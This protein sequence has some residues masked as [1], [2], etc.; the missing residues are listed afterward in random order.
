[1]DCGHSGAPG[2]MHSYEKIRDKEDKEETE[3][4][5]NAI[6]IFMQISYKTDLISR[7]SCRKV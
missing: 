5:G 2:H 7:N 6:Y 3:K 1:M 4:G